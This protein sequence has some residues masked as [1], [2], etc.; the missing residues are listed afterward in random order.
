MDNQIG[1]NVKDRGHQFCGVVTNVLRTSFNTTYVEVSLLTDN[2]NGFPDPVWCE[3]ERLQTL[4]GRRR[5]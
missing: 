3:P 1:Q 2:P 5:G 4:G